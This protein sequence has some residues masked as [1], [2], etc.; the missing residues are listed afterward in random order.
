M[1]FFTRKQIQQSAVQLLDSNPGGMR[2]SDLLKAIHAEASE[3]P[4]N[5]IHGALHALF[6]KSD[7]ITKIARGTY[8]LNKHQD[9]QATNADQADSD[10]ASIKVETPSHVKVTLLEADFYDSFA[11][12]L[13][14]VADE[15]TVA[16]ALGGSLLKGKWGTPDVMG[17]LRH[18]A[19]DTLKFEPQIVSAEI[20]ID[21]AQPVTA[22]GQA[23][24]YRLFSHKAYIVVPRTTSEDDL[25]RLKALCVIHGVGLVTFSLDKGAPDYTSV[26]LPSLG[27]PDI[28]YANK[29]LRRLFDANS[30]LFNKL[31]Q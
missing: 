11:Q 23:V 25:G 30:K 1:A 20:K 9:A 10:A 13:V 16:V 27:S 5:S 6:A 4:P 2:W 14:D 21:P 18:G 22:F 29:I 3:T 19:Q 28:F 17:V 7:E 8:Q 15:V 12:W 31:F 24:A 26:I